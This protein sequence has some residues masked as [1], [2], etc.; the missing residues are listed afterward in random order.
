MLDYLILSPLQL[1][2]KNINNCGPAIE[3]YSVCILNY[4][5]FC[6]NKASLKVRMNNASC[7]W[8]SH[9]CIYWE[10]IRNF[11]C[12]E[13]ASMYLTYLHPEDHITNTPDLANII[14]A[15]N[16]ISRIVSISNL[17]NSQ[18]KFLFRLLQYSNDYIYGPSPWNVNNSWQK[19]K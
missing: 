2:V 19:E 9:S 11:T 13:S 18:P 5:R 16:T 17:S 7:F 15:E 12:I 4:Y 1:F 10:L 8:C 14:R 6:S 3:G